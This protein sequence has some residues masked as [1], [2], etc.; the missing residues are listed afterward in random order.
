M[1]MRRGTVKS[2]NIYDIYEKAKKL[3][4]VPDNVTLAEY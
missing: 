4:K 3:T 1:C 2:I